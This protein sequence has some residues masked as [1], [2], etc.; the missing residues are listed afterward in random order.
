MF[1]SR[2]QAKFFMIKLLQ[3]MTQHCFVLHRDPYSLT[4]APCAIPQRVGGLPKRYGVDNKGLH[5]VTAISRNVELGRA[6]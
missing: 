1:E 5:W 4:K 2:E 6:S 3:K